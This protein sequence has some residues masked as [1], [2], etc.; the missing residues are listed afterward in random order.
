MLLSLQRNEDIGDPADI[1]FKINYLG[2]TYKEEIED[3]DLIEA[4]RDG[5]SH[6][7]IV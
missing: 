5:V 2:L 6:I 1:V 4:G 3:L 7:L